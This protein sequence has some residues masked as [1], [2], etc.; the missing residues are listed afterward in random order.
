MYK[1]TSC[2]ILASVVS[3][4]TKFLTDA[5]VVDGQEVEKEPE[6]KLVF[7]EENQLGGMS[8]LKDISEADEQ[9]KMLFTSYK[10]LINARENNKYETLVPVK[11]SQQVIAGMKYT[12]VYDTGNYD[13]LIEVTIVQPLPG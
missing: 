3:A 12:I 6:A 9:T 1:F 11:Y 13:K 7:N 4:E 10:A 8:K 5:V 2:L